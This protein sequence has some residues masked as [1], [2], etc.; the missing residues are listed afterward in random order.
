MLSAGK[1]GQSGAAGRTVSIDAGVAR[2]L[3]A[4]PRARAPPGACTAAIVAGRVAAAAAADP[5]A[6]D[7]ARA[8]VTAAPQ[9]ANAATTTAP[10][11][12]PAIGVRTL[13]SWHEPPG[14]MALPA[15]SALPADRGFRAPAS[16]SRS[17]S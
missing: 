4:A 2:T 15:R 3:A 10:N 7:S 1:I 11:A 14:G 8:P 6:A 17:Y 13:A 5:A 12:I 16:R 9:P